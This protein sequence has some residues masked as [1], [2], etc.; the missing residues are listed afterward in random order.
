MEILAD[1]DVDS[2]IKKAIFENGSKS[3][4]LVLCSC[5]H[6]V[7]AGNCPLTQEEIESLKKYHLFI[8]KL[9]SLK[10]TVAQKRALL[11]RQNQKADFG[12]LVPL[13]E[14]IVGML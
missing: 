9:A 11:R 14:V 13:L 10:D 8:H 5:A 6:N 2:K 4:I 3:V 12:G 1:R 7:L